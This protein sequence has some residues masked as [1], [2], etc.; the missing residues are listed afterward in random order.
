MAETV[1]FVPK[2]SSTLSVRAVPQLPVDDQIADDY[3]PPFD[4]RQLAL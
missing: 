3:V 2:T 1:R 4:R